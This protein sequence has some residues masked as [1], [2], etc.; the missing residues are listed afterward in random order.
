MK[1]WAIILLAL[2]VIAPLAQA[3]PEERP[4]VETEVKVEPVEPF[5]DV[6]DPNFTEKLERAASNIGKIV[7]TEDEF[8]RRTA[9][10]KKKAEQINAQLKQQRHT[11]WVEGYEKGY[12]AGRK[13]K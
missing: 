4:A 8:V 7:I 3:A 1:K 9:A 12:D 2:L 11:I 6:T 10:L 5:L 13:K